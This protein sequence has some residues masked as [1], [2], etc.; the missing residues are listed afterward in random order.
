MRIQ[1]TKIHF[2]R[3]YLSNS[4]ELGSH[5]RSTCNLIILKMGLEK[6][7]TPELLAIL[8]GSG[9]ITWFTQLIKRHFP[10]YDPKIIVLGLSFILATSY[11]G[12]SA[13]LSLETKTAVLNFMASTAGLSVL[14]YE[15]FKKLLNRTE[16][17]KKGV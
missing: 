7:F 11:T 14:L 12:L 9:G 5:L 8:L 15:F 3:E 2:R 1:R 16:T 4:D 10:K 17:E 13:F 6:I